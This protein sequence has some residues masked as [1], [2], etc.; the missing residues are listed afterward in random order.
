[1]NIDHI[2]YAVKRIDKSIIAFESLGYTF[3]DVIDDLDRNIKMAFG[4]KDGYIIELVSV[5]DKKQQ[6]PVDKYLSCIGST[7]YHICYRTDDINK[8]ITD[9][10]N[11]GYKLI[12]EPKDAIAF[13][14]KKVAFL[15]NLFIGLIELVES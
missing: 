2:G 10:T 5:L 11:T 8:S 3:G 9:L 1:M 4:E 6:S 7:P 14:G 13:G 12:I 15:F